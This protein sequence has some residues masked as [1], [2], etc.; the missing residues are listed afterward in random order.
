MEASAGATVLTAVRELLPTL[1]ERAQETEDRRALSAETVKSLAE[2]GF[3][4]LLQP[5]RFGGLE[6][7]PLTFLT[8]VRDV[9][10]ACGSTGWVS[11]V[12]GVHNWQLALF[13]DQ[14]Q[15]D[16]WAEDPGTRM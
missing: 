10:A 14:A 3:F 2:T 15:Q 4:R 12:I 16:V 6:A 7:D 5:A 9:A 13:P 1:R 8:G 11:S